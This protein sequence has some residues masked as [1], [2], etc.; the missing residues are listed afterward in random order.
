MMASRNVQCCTVHAPSLESSNTATR[1]T[2]RTVMVAVPLRDVSRVLVARTTQLP[3][4]VGATNCTVA[5]LPESVPQVLLQFTPRTDV[6]VT[7]AVSVVPSPRS[8]AG[9]A[10]VTATITGV[11]VA[12]AVARLAGSRTLVAETV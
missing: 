4:E 12:V 3:A 5:P 11:T 7:A 10:A 9:V 2:G 8:S 1:K 6:P